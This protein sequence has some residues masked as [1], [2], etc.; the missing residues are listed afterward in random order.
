MRI[1]VSG[2]SGFIGS[3]LV[4]TLVA[5][6]HECVATERSPK[7]GELLI[8]KLPERADGV[9]NLA[10]ESV[11][12]LWTPAKKRRILES[13]VR[14]TDALAQWAVGAGVGVFVSGSAV[15]YYGDR[16]NESIDESTSLDPE[17][18]FRAV[19]CRDWEAAARVGDIRTVFLRTGNV[20]D[21]S[22]GYME[23]F[24]N[25]YR[26][27]PPIGVADPN[28]WFP[29][30]SLDD[31]VGLI[32]FALS[33]EVMSGPVNLVAPVAAR[34]GDFA[35]LLARRFGKRILFSLKPWMLTLALRGMA[36]TFTDSQRIVPSKALGLGYEFKLPELGAFFAWS[37]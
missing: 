6:G 22:G 26:R 20:L 4:E 21:P 35:E 28:A 5:R 7:T 31:E 11:V 32:E 17:L 36:A 27:F 23:V 37:G 30:I 14:T 16:G 13:R 33:C 1:V 2:A 18:Q 3:R 34:N 25:L 10:G 12:G 19:V 29:W 24:E 15:G 9:V 8:D